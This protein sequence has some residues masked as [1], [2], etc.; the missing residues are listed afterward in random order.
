MGLYELFFAT[1]EITLPV[2]AMVF[3]GLGLKRLGWIDQAFI[4]TASSLVFKATMPTLIFLSIIRADLDTT[5]NP[6]ML[7]F[8]ALATL[9]SFL[10]SWGWAILRV[11]Y[12]DRGVYVQGAFRGNCGIVGLALAAGMYGDY[13][14]SAGGLLL[15]VVILTYN[16]FSVIVLATYQE[17]KSADWRSIAS[18]IARNPLILAV[19]AAIPVAALELRLPGWAM[20]SGQYFASLTLPLALICIG[21]TLSLGS[22]RASGSLA[23]GASLMKMITLPVVAILAAWLVG[24]EG[25]ELGVL[26][27]FFASP[28]AAAA[29]VM[30]KAMGG[31]AAL[32]ANIIALTTLMASVTITLGVFALKVIGWI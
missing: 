10:L 28:T 5:L 22:I 16:A 24:F 29:F 23:M 7:A 21:A 31:N 11:P 6:A 18:H 3:I 12:A 2:F 1:L 25:R 20:T 15:G 26:F 9:G 17:G 4:S 27:L 19:V 13:G 30:T 8:F 14:L 32:S